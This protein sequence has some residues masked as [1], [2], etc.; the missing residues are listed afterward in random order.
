MKTIILAL[1]MLSLLTACTPRIGVGIG[2][3]VVSD[4][5]LSGTEVHADSQIGIGGSIVTGGDIRL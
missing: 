3:A 4:N 5:G 2:G 1:F